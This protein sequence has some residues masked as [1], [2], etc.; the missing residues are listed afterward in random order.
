MH[1][2]DVCFAAF[3]SNTNF[4]ITASTDGVVKFWKKV[5]GSVEFV[6]EFKAHDGEVKSLS[7][8]S[9]GK[10][11]ATA[12]PD[13][14]VKLFDVENFDM[15]GIIKVDFIPKTICWIHGRGAS[16]P[17]LAVSAEDQPRILI[18]DGRGTKAEPIHEVDSAHD[19]PIHAI[20]FN[21]RYDCAVSADETGYIEYWSPKHAYQAP[22]N[23]WQW[24]SKTDFAALN[25]DKVAPASLTISPTGEQLAMFTFPDR[26]V[27]I[28][29]FRTA[30]LLSV[31]DESLATYESKRRAGEGAA[32][33]DFE[34]AP[35]K[36][37]DPAK[38]DKEFKRRVEVEEEI[39]RSPV[40]RR[41]INILYDESGNFILYGTL[42]GIKLLNT[43]TN[44]TVK[45]FGTQENYR[46]LHLALYQGAPERK[47]IMTAAMAASENPLLQEASARDPM[48]VATGFCKGAKSHPDQEG[49]AR[50]YMTTNDTSQD[51][52]RP[53]KTRDVRNEKLGTASAAKQAAA[54]AKPAAIAE[55]A[56]M[57]TSQGDIQ[58]RLFPN[59]A[60][61]AVE[62]F[63]TH[64]RNG[65]Y[66]NVLFHRVIKKFMIQTGDPLG[67]GTGGE[68]IWGREFAD[69]I[70][71]TLRHDRYML[72]MA[73][74]GPNTN[75]S[76]FFITTDRSP[77]LDGKH[78][79]FGR[80]VAGFDVVHAIENVRVHKE[81]PVEDV[82]VINIEVGE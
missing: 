41:R 79:I 23:V 56:T 9:E 60:P 45:V 72:S 33:L 22:P 29:D 61:K 16:L 64:S 15:Y 38:E 62:N 58:L 12:G 47:G 5:L 63:V 67:D 70:S 65:Y 53:S 81:K 6:K 71:G 37:R 8:S 31:Y 59:Q 54:A 10:F 69:E 82:R 48:I 46:P 57:H 78:T 2:T 17:L 25:R 28:F 4:L 39:E 44:T 75:G 11:L 80:V 49:N 52:F 36:P 30:K 14:T 18:Y 43:Y 68:S 24:L 7:V 55:L 51:S 74:A 27:R 19:D 77:W 32:S 42:Y 73:N 20:V 1:K 35:D 13:S 26:Q 3:T 34:T 21:P 40:M 76:Q 50:F 66:D